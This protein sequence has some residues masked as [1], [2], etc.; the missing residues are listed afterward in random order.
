MADLAW[1]YCCTVMAA[2]TMRQSNWGARRFQARD[3]T[4]DHDFDPEKVVHKSRISGKDLEFMHLA[5]EQAKKCVPVETAYNVGAVI[6]DTANG[7]VLSVGYS[8]E[9]PGNTHAEQCALDKLYSQDR[10]SAG[11]LPDTL[12]VYT[13]M[14]PCS[15]RLSGNKPCAERIL[16]S[17]IK[18]VFIAVLEPVHF[19][20]CKGKGMLEDSGINVIH[21]KELEEE[22][23]ALNSHIFLG[24]R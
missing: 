5:I 1:Q 15:K 8:R 2:A 13:T 9:I 12:A 24:Q 6:A 7:E 10:Y 22:C 23:K 19:V 21:L 16:E 20:N 18:L 14:E 11:N 4:E 3:V 17:G